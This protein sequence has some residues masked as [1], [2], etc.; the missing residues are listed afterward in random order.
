MPAVTLVLSWSTLQ[1]FDRWNISRH[2]DTA[3]FRGTQGWESQK[4][5]T[6]TFHLRVMSTF[7]TN[8]NVCF[9]WVWTRESNWRW[10]RPI[11]WDSHWCCLF[12]R[13]PPHPPPARPFSTFTAQ[14]S[15]QISIHSPGAGSITDRGESRVRKDEER[16]SVS[17][18]PGPWAFVTFAP[19]RGD[20]FRQEKRC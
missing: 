9:Y 7:Q 3:G 19:E 16:Q 10:T 18:C 11:T 17:D 14:T 5:I 4:L 12:C 13:S 6:Q 20:R 1:L 15:T 2:I 8:A